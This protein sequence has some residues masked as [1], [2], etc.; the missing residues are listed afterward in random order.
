[1]TL[2]LWSHVHC[3]KSLTCLRVAVVVR[4]VCVCVCGGG[5]EGSG[6]T[7]RVVNL[8]VG[9]LIILWVIYATS[10]SWIGYL[11]HY[12]TL[13]YIHVRATCMHWWSSRTLSL[14]RL[15]ATCP[16]VSPQRF[17]VSTDNERHLTKRWI[18]LGMC[19]VWI[20]VGFH[21]KVRARA[22]T[23]PP[24]WSEGATRIMV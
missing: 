8:R 12:T 7:L 14:V 10:K 9:L 11:K 19:V 17:S 24:A 1:M 16:F 13:S 5:G 22:Y 18:H 21:I 23:L 20:M 6:S 3:R 2:R 15:S 4:D